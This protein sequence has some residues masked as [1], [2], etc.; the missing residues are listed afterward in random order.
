MKIFFKLKIAIYIS[1]VIFLIPTLFSWLLYLIPGGY[2]R[3]PFTGIQMFYLSFISFISSFSF[4]MFSDSK[5]LFIYYLVITSILLLVSLGF[6]FYQKRQKVFSSPIFYLFLISLFAFV[7]M[8]A[9]KL[10][11]IPALIPKESVNFQVVDPPSGFN[12]VYRSI[13]A[14]GERSDNK[15]EILG[16]LDNDNLIYKKWFRDSGNQISGEGVILQYNFLSKKSN[17]FSGSVSNLSNK[18]CSYRECISEFVEHSAD[19]QAFGKDAWISPN[20]K[21]FAYLSRYIYGPED[22]MIFEK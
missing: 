8:F 9:F 12:L 18:R 4:I 19:D 7:Y 22:I 2:F 5:T 11:Y 6:I 1:T 16:W 13:L 20:G 21:R 14:S 10:R 3:G 15:F 17:H